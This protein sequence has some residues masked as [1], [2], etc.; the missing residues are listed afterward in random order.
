VTLDNT[1]S[2]VEAVHKIGGR[3]MV[4]TVDSATTA[5]NLFSSG[6]DYI[7]TNSILPSEITALQTNETNV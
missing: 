2:I 6:T 1:P 5:Y 4:W 3:A 7:L